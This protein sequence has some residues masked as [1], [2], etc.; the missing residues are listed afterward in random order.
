MPMRDDC[1][2]ELSADAADLGNTTFVD[3]ILWSCPVNPG[4]DPPDENAWGY[5]ARTRVEMLH[6]TAALRPGPRLPEVLE[7]FRELKP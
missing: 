7:R 4:G 3:G 1:A 6:Y 5:L 2:E